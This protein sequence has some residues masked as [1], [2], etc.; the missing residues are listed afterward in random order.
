[1]PIEPPDPHDIRPD[2]ARMLTIL[3]GEVAKRPQDPRILG[4]MGHVAAALAILDA[5][6]APPPETSP[7]QA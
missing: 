6:T 4:A 5:P 2:L 3:R 1:M 7:M